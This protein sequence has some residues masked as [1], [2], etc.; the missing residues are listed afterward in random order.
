M[1]ERTLL[2]APSA[3]RHPSGSSGVPAPAPAEFLELFARMAGLPPAGD[4]IT[5][6]DFGAARASANARLADD[7]FRVIESPSDSG[8]GPGSRRPLATP[9]RSVDVAAE[10]AARARPVAESMGPSVAPSAGSGAAPDAVGRQPATGAVTEAPPKPPAGAHGSTTPVTRSIGS[11]PASAPAAAPPP[12]GVPAVSADPSA[13]R[14][15]ETRVT[16]AAASRAAAVLP[17]KASG[18][19]AAGAGPRGDGGV[20]GQARRGTLDGRPTVTKPDPAPLSDTART[21]TMGDV[22]RVLRANLQQGHSVVRLQL[23]P[24]E[25]GKLTIDLQLEHDRL[26]VRIQ[27]DHAS[28]RDLLAGRSTL[29]SDSL[30]SQG[31]TIE[32]YE[33][34]DAGA[35]DP[36]PFG[37]PPPE[38]RRD[39]SRSAGGDDA[40]EAPGGDTESPEADDPPGSAVAPRGRG[41]DLKA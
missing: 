22:L 6:A 13:S 25:L 4:A 7:D 15:S 3:D 33:V 8:S 41:L 16:V 37:Q 14:S 9:M 35:L 24:P 38:A 12:V 2:S 34:V 39:F 29:L 40:S 5:A 1:I 21:R 23:Q 32:R 20:S 18:D 27:A 31:I 17:V 19:A 26:R 28:V 11:E 30:A 10:S 36:R